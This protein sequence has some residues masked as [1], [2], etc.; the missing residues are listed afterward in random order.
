MPMKSLPG[1]GQARPY[2]APS[3]TSLRPP[4]PFWS[5]MPSEAQQFLLLSGSCWA[6]L[7]EM[8]SGPSAL[9]FPCPSPFL[10]LCLSSHLLAFPHSVP[11]LS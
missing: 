9:C 1:P 3:P 10:F 4:P 7:P 2:F 6:P 11:Q 5:Q 8:P